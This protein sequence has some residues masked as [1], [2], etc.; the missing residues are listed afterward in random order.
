[1]SN[2]RHL[3]ERLEYTWPLSQLLDAQSDLVP[4]SFSDILK[5]KSEGDE[6][7]WRRSGNPF[8][9][10]R[11]NQSHEHRQQSHLLGVT[12]VED[13]RLSLNTSLTVLKLWQSL[14]ASEAQKPVT[15]GAALWGSSSPRRSSG[16]KAKRIY[17]AGDFSTKREHLRMKMQIVVFIFWQISREASGFVRWTSDLSCHCHPPGMCCERSPVPLSARSPMTRCCSGGKEERGLLRRSS[18]GFPHRPGCPSRSC[19]LGG[20]RQVRT[21]SLGWAAFAHPNLAQKEKQQKL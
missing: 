17:E 18:A 16:R 21:F 2:F 1:M 9:E 19:K 3:F 4:R 12:L 6:R 5:G 10:S 13:V 15:P 20:W 8:I 7:L 11:C 14:Y